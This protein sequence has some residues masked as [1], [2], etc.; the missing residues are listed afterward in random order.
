MKDYAA[1]TGTSLEGFTPSD[2]DN[3]RVEGSADTE[4]RFVDGVLEGAITLAK[5][6]KDVSALWEEQ[7]ETYMA[8][9]LAEG[10]TW[11]EAEL[12][13][14]LRQVEKQ[15]GKTFLAGEN[16][17]NLI[18]GFSFVAR[19]YAAGNFADLNFGQK[20]KHVLNLL[21]EKIAAAFSLS[22]DLRRL[23]QDGEL[24]P[25]L[26]SAIRESLGF[27]GNQEAEMGRIR[28]A[29]ASRIAGDTHAISPI[30]PGPR[31]ITE[32]P[33]VVTLSNPFPEGMAQPTELRKHF[34]ENFD[35]LTAAW[36]KTIPTTEGPIAWSKSK[37]GHKLRSFKD[38][39]PALLH[40]I[41]AANLPELLE[42]ST[43]AT[44]EPETKGD[45]NVQEVHKRYAWADFP[46]GQR[47][48]VLLTVDRMSEHADTDKQ[49]ADQAYSSEVLGITLEVLPEKETTADSLNAD[50]VSDH[51]A[52]VDGSVSESVTREIGEGNA[53]S[54]QA[55]N[56][57][58]GNLT[59]FLSGIKP[60]HRRTFSISRA[61][62][63]LFSV[64]ALI[65][66]KSGGKSPAAKVW[67][68]MVGEVR[69]LRHRFDKRA[70]EMAGENAATLERELGAIDA[71]E[72]AGMAEASARLE[73]D[74][75]ALE[76]RREE[77]RAVH[78][79]NLDRL[80]HEEKIA[81]QDE[82]E[83]LLEKWRP[84]RANKARTAMP[85]A[86]KTVAA[87]F[88]GLRD[89]EA[90]R[91]RAAMTE[92]ETREKTVRRDA[93]DRER[94]ASRTAKG[95]EGNLKRQADRFREQQRRFELLQDV[96]TLE[97]IAKALPALV[98]AKFFT[99]FRKLA[100]LRTVEAR[101][102]Y[103][104][105]LLPKVE[106]ALESHLRREY[107]AAIRKQL[108]KGA[109]KV[110]E[111][112]NRSSSIGAVAAAIFEEAKAAAKL[113]DDPLGAVGG[114]TAA[115]KAQERSEAIS[116]LIEGTG[117]MNAE[118]MEELVGR[119][120]AVELLGDFGNANSTR[121][122]QALDFLTGA[123]DEGRK[124]RVAVLLSRREVKESRI[125]TILKGLGVTKAPETKDRSLR[126]RK[127]E[128]FLRGMAEGFMGG[129]LSGS[130]IMRRLR[131]TTTDAEVVSTVEDMEVAF[132]FAELAEQDLNLADN[133]RYTAA[134][135]R[136][137][138]VKT[139][140]GFARKLSELRAN[141]E[142][143]VPVTKIEG[144]RSETVSIPLRHIEAI[145]EGDLDALEAGG[146]KID[147]AW[148]DLDEAD[149]TQLEAEWELFNQL[150]PEEQGRKR[151][152]T[153]TRTLSEGERKT[154]GEISQLEG[155]QWYLT[156]RQPDQFAKLE[157]MGWDAQTVAELET[158][159]KPEVKELGNW[160]VEDLR[161]DRD[162]I[163]AIH[164]DEKGVGLAILDGPYFPVV[165]EKSAA[166]ME[167]LALDG[168]SKP[169]SGRSVGSLK[170]RVTN[171]AE[172]AVV[173]ALA[174]YL[175]HKAQ[176]NFWK[177]NV[178]VLREWGGIIRDDK[179][180]T[181]VKNTMGSEYYAAL[182][183]RLD[184]IEAGG[185]LRQTPLLW[186]ERVFKKFIRGFALGTLGGR[187]S[188]LAVNSAAITNVTLEVPYSELLVGMKDVMANPAAFKDA[189][190]SP[191]IRRRM[192][193]GATFEAQLAKQ[194][195]A[196]MGPLMS[197]ADAAAMPA[198]EAINFVDTGANT[199]AAA[200]VWE[201]TRKQALAQGATD[202]EAR[203][204]ADRK[205]EIVMARAAQPTTRFG[206]SEFELTLLESPLALPFAMFMSEARKT[207]S[208]GA[209]AVR[210]ILTGKGIYSKGMAWQQAISAL[211][212]IKA[213]EFSIRAIVGAATKGKDDEDEE[214]LGRLEK[215]MAD[216]KAWAY[217]LTAD[218]LTAIPGL[219]EAGKS[220][221]TAGI[222]S[223][224][225][226]WII[227]NT[228][229]ADFAE[230][231]Q[232]SELRYFDSNPNPL[233][234][235]GKGISSTTKAFSEDLTAEERADKII[236]SAQVLGTLI[237]GAAIAA[238]VANVAEAGLGAFNSFGGDLSDEDK[239]KRLKSRY[240]RL[241]K[242]LDEIHGPT[243][244][245][246][247]K[248]DRHGKPRK[249]AD[250]AVQSA[251]EAALADHLRAALAPLSPELRKQVLAGVRPTDAIEKRVSK[252]LKS[253]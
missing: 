232:K 29:A 101:Q 46:N 70:L 3:F 89:K 20:L 85:E 108:K 106:Q 211:V 172:P 173:N 235:V 25:A 180:A 102:N 123:F 113:A 61:G 65:S 227:E 84:E 114:K 218:H 203:A 215:R 209:M 156:L 45:R 152:L 237:P 202:A 122:E 109:A 68:N 2:F 247:G 90:A 210:Q 167:S 135:Y 56:P 163:D 214:Y 230:R 82:G 48:H 146:V 49:Q 57:D 229:P 198:M 184:R 28:N 99:G 107:R 199:V 212:V 94:A 33:A 79:Q 100:E 204:S 110:S 250:K 130:Q 112:R 221:L 139:K 157:K 120:Q 6:Q 22:K 219:G 238:Q 17:E 171:Q 43:L 80:E 201:R 42:S 192:K 158:W 168:I 60:G 179:F 153:F 164:R 185:S 144:A 73:T 141:R 78:A 32:A 98:R 159:L 63:S 58:T 189:W 208:I 64:P 31:D 253:E 190:N 213:L 161:A 87:R 71:R 246:T 217:A 224:G 50:P 188:T 225:V 39:E 51:V 132:S 105:D 137:L 4:A 53:S 195:G 15:T 124:E 14:E 244:K 165:N 191:A 129:T 91:H 196:G 37:T 55:R 183:R 5:G 119:Q 8:A 77:E 234:S 154:L 83:R 194:K 111:G 127:D 197:V 241:R 143:N 138:G 21:A 27:E 95:R 131:E 54:N 86:R 41:A 176:M 206:R 59:Q 166:D 148:R 35:L 92:L 252:D 140:Y 162:T 38:G 226:K 133:D 72:A 18:E 134:A 233:A 67:K 174:V 177:A 155:L 207:T 118:R 223:E 52:T 81:V 243:M 13:E 147:P 75:A 193:G 121:L 47:R 34:W 125:S 249:K 12:L 44:V 150:S 240:N 93:R 136:I 216:P 26:E 242:E 24:S 96:G 16:R 186:I 30:G 231:W 40:F 10:G 142:G 36:P 251:K 117:E 115:E 239:V 74:L 1:Q 169:G 200:F 205:V 76:E 222:N 116:R 228:M 248:L 23:S 19:N 170:M 104:A 245:E 7:S 175:S 181:A 69:G 160:M 103:L 97:V 187:V 178:G 145:L 88:K 149:L 182:K 220:G 62:D 128:G 66:V 11:T 151:N 126:T 236:D 9:Q